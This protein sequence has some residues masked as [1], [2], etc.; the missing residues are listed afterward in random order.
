MG[1]LSPMK[2][3]T[4]KMGTPCLILFRLSP[5]EVTIFQIFSKRLR[6]RLLKIVKKF[7]YLYLDKNELSSY[8][9][10]LHVTCY[11]QRINVP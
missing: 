1:P 5:Y 7:D 10:A 2:I 9:T 4:L 6:L 3:F 8:N 11:E